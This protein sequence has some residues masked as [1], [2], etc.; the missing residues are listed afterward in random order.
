MNFYK[1]EQSSLFYFG[2]AMSVGEV[3]WK[4]IEVMKEK[5]SIDLG[6]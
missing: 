6:K 4:A 2:H 3:I 1:K 5:G